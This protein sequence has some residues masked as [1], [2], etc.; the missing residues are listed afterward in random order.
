[1]IDGIEKS[2][3]YTLAELADLGF[4]RMQ[5]SR[6]VA[7]GKAENPARGIYRFPLEDDGE[8]NYAWA[9]ISRQ[10]PGALF[11]L[12]SAAV[13]H[14]ISEDLG[15]TRYVAL[16][17]GQQRRE[18]K[19]VKF[20]NWGGSG[21][22]DAGVD[23]IQVDG[24]DVRITSP[25]RTLV[26]MFRYSDQCLADRRRKR[27]VGADAMADCLRRYLSKFG[28]PGRKSFVFAKTLGIQDEFPAYIRTV[29]AANPDLWA[30]AGR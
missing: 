24:V 12:Y 6:M 13:H 16:P 26:D 8:V 15:M 11:C 17:K 5:L 9:A 1:M 22:L 21:E 23:T 27:V 10:V 25:E 4:S 3:P 29:Q 18:R 20:L 7:A 14:G 28:P 30:E 2:R 19:G